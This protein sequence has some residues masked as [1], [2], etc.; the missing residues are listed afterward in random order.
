MHSSFE[1]IVNTK[2]KYNG[3]DKAKADKAAA[4][5]RKQ[6]R[7]AKRHGGVLDDHS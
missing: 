5:L 2:P 3:K 7:E 6:R 1:K 4:K